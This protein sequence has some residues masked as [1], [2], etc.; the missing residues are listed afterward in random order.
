M[1]AIAKTP[2]Q[3]AATQAELARKIGK[4]ARTITTWTKRTDWPFGTAGPF[5]VA[6]VRGW[7][8]RTLRRRPKNETDQLD[9]AKDAELVL[10][11]ERAAKL[12]QER[13]IEA[14]KY[15]ERSVYRRCIVALVKSVRDKLEPLFESLPT[16]IGADD[17]E[18]I[19]GIV[20]AMY[21]RFCEDMMAEARVA[22]ATEEEVDQVIAGKDPMKVKAARRR[23]RG[24]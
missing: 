10:K 22:L 17:P 15:V 12:R 18:R 3:Q 19:R 21:D 1:P 20:N 24:R 2:R 7:Q 23:R 6:E 16:V 11:R 5:D 9:P 4:S 13:E 14:G 8:R